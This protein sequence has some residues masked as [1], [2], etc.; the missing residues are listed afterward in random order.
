VYFV[1]SAYAALCSTEFLSG[2]VLNVGAGVVHA[3]PIYEAHVLHHGIMRLDIAG[4]DLTEMLIKPLV[5]KVS[6]C[7]HSM[8]IPFPSELHSPL[9]VIC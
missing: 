9:R 3:V 8:M 4:N 5:S 7:L 6:L 2:L 1:S